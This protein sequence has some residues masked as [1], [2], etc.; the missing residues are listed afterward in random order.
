VTSLLQNQCII[1]SYQSKYK[2]I[3]LNVMDCKVTPHIFLV[4]LPMNKNISLSGIYHSDCVLIKE[5][6]Y[7]GIS[8]HN[9]Q[10]LFNSDKCKCILIHSDQYSRCP[11]SISGPFKQ[12]FQQCNRLFQSIFLLS[13][14]GVT[15]TC[16]NILYVCTRSDNLT[17][18]YN[19]SIH[20][21][22][23]S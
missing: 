2:H 5:I 1:Y 21:G 6:I 4:D 11:D 15:H 23:Y 22:A 14:P 3:Q 13:Q 7:T 10:I 12:K 18:H 20:E 16:L 17:V 9:L 8:T 19:T